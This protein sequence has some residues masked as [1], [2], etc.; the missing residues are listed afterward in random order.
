MKQLLRKLFWPI[1]R[2]FET[3]NVGSNYKS[4]H[5]VILIVV[6]FLFFVLSVASGAASVY[7]N[8]LGALI[9]VVIFFAIS[10]VAI[11]VGT[12][13]SDGAVSKIWGNK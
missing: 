5:R 3:D 1:L 2:F 4:S 8:E 11:V 6:G 12:L 13:G 9:P 7:A 10:L